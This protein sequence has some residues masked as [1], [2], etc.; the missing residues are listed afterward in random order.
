MVYRS[1]IHVFN[2]SSDPIAV[3]INDNYTSMNFAMEKLLGIKKRRGLFGTNIYDINDEHGGLCAF[4]NIETN[5]SQYNSIRILK[6]VKFTVDVAE[7]V[8]IKGADNTDVTQVLPILTFLNDICGKLS[9]EKSKSGITSLTIF[10][11]FGPQTLTVA[12]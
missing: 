7:N 6:S 11:L 10:L 4:Y 8:T 3:A 2:T 5:S 1:C 9:S 12:K